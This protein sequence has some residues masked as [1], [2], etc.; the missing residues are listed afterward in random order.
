MESISALDNICANCG[1]GEENSNNLKKCSACLSVKYC[2]TGCQK[3]HRSQ[4]KKECKKRAAQLH[5]E[6]LFK[7]IEREECPICMLPLSGRE[8]SE[9][10]MT[11]C[12]KTICNGCIY[13]MKMS[14]GN[15]MCDF[16][17]HRWQVIT[18]K[19]TK[20]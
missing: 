10:F 19:T 5:D 16:V 20:G 2:S 18:R 7:E 6:K 13:T 9:S 17:G 14:E 12:G 15:T 3:A 4:H 8:M 1:K 11:C